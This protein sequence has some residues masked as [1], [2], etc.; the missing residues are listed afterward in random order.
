MLKEFTLALFWA[1]AMLP[2]EKRF[3][4]L[5]VLLLSCMKPMES[6]ICWPGARSR[7]M[8]P[9]EPE[10]A[11]ARILERDLSSDIAECCLNASSMAV[12]RSRHS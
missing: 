6:C 9:A 12:S 3:I 7:S 8:T 5:S 1:V 4:P 10:Q 11:G 2:W